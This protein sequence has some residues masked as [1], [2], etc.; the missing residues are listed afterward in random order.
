MAQAERQKKYEQSKKDNGFVR[1]QYWVRPEWV[2][3]IKEFINQLK[4]N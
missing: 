2:E 1:K 3:K 4:E